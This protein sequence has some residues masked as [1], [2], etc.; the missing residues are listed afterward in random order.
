MKHL[1][2]KQ[3]SLYLLEKV[4]EFTP[5]GHDG[6]MNYVLSQTAQNPPSQM[7]SLSILCATK[8]CQ[9]KHLHSHSAFNYIV[10]YCITSSL[11]HARR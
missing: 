2:S 1:F 11:P 7:F 10:L 6:Q 8:W 3:K 9:R 5:V 4:F